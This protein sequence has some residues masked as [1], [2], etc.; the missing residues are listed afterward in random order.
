MHVYI[1][2]Y[3][4]TLDKFLISSIWI[5]VA[6]KSKTNYIRTYW[7]TSFYIYIS[8]W[9]FLRRILSYDSNVIF[10]HFLSTVVEIILINFHP[11]VEIG[12]KFNDKKNPSWSISLNGKSSIR[13]TIF[14]SQFHTRFLLR[15]LV[16]VYFGKVSL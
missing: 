10:F 12:K 5:G 8:S 3:N 6:L 9:W 7:K 11:R 4:A 14:S 13:C 1:I 15:L 16:E 2:L